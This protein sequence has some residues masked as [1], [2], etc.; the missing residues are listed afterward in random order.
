MFTCEHYGIE[1]DMLV[2][3]KSL[4]GGVLPLAAL[5]ARENLDVAADRAIGH[6]THEKSPVACAA[7]LAAI[8][9]LQ[10]EDLPA[11][12]ESMGNYTMERLGEMKQRNSLIGEVRGLGLLIGIE[13]VKD[14][15]T[16]E[17]A[18]KQAEQVMYSALSKGL[19][20]KVTMGNI[21]TLTPALTITK[22]QMDKALGILDE[23]LTEAENV[24]Q[25]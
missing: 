23:C 15:R 8:E 24:A 18:T 20:F 19:S 25:I 11:Q 4:G 10:Q 5:I 2:I 6:Y 17:P 22:D 9:Y 3:G 21:I 14:S 16:K 12:A 13:L 1:P 7:A